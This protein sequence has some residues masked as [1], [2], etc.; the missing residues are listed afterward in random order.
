[1]PVLATGVPFPSPNPTLRVENQ[2]PPGAYVFQLVC[3]DEDGNES[4]PKQITVTVRP[5]IIVDPIPGGVVRP[6]PIDPD[7]RRVVLPGGGMV[8]RPMRPM[9]PG[10]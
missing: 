2:L 5:R 3:V 4:E 1:M 8:V 7:L 10:G 6:R 9:R